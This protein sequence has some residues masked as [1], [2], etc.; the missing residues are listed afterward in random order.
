MLLNSL[1]IKEL[2]SLKENHLLLFGAFLF[3]K[4]SFSQEV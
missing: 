1:C 2:F 3:G 4:L